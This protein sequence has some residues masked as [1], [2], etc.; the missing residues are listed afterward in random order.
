MNIY[1]IKDPSPE[2]MAFRYASA[3]WA[4]ASDTSGKM[5]PRSVGAKEAF[6]LT[7]L[8]ETEMEQRM[9][10]V[11]A[12]PPVTLDILAEHAECIAFLVGKF[13]YDLPCI[14]KELMR[15]QLSVDAFLKVTLNKAA[16]DK[17]A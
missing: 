11:V 13:D 3:C 14:Q 6:A 16:V 4:R 8:L 5:R 2:L 17:A 9:Q 10:E 12:R 1:E 7:E 15:L